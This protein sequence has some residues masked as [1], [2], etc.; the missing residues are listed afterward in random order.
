M[1]I[2]S[3]SATICRLC[4]IHS[5]ETVD[6]FEQEGLDCDLCFYLPLEVSNAVTI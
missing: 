5:E 1:G 3:E 6:I 2:L 4:G